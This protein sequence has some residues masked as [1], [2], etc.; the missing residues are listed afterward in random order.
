MRKIDEKKQA[1]KNNGDQNEPSFW[2]YD[3]RELPKKAEN[4]WNS[5]SAIFK[6]FN[7]LD[8]ID[9]KNKKSITAGLNKIIRNSKNISQALYIRKIKKMGKQH[10][11]TIANFYKSK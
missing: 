2:S 7:I 1:G 4:V 5:L 9:P 3:L 10:F 8:E 6:N 11:Q